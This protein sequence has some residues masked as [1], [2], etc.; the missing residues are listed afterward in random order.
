M[1]L[2][3]VAHPNLPINK[4]VVLPE[5]TFFLVS[6]TTKIQNIISTPILYQSVSGPQQRQEP[7]PNIESHAP[8]LRIRLQ[9]FPSNYPFKV[10][11][12]KRIN[13]C[14]FF[15]SDFCPIYWATCHEM[16]YIRL[17]KYNSRLRCEGR[18][19]E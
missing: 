14:H 9:N 19:K 6:A 18:I 12:S 8:L 13:E 17:D 4:Y 5:Y 3:S 15:L 1:T 10:V 16:I 7:N 11:L 2:S